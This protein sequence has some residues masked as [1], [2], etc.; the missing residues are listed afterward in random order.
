MDQHSDDEDERIQIHSD[1]TQPI[2][3]KEIKSIKKLLQEINRKVK[4]DQV[5]SVRHLI[6]ESELSCCCC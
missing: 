5:H 4:E 2:A 6:S 3:P 1:E